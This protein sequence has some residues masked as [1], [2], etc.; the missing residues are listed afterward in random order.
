MASFGYISCLGI[1]FADF[2][3][4]LGLQTKALTMLPSFFFFCY[5]LV[6][7]FA[8]YLFSRFSVRSVGICGAIVICSGSMLV[9]LVRTLNELLI[10][11]SVMQG[12]YLNYLYNNNLC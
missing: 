5:C 10:A 11:Y 6:G 4:D 1:M 12:T 2:L 7:L 8:N 9:V 3:S